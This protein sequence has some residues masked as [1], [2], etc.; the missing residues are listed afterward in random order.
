VRSNYLQIATLLVYA[1]IW[2]SIAIGNYDRVLAQ[3]SLAPPTPEICNLDL[4]AL[5]SGA[6]S[7]DRQMIT[8]DTVTADGMT[9]P[10]LWWTSEQFPAKLIANWLA[11]TRQKQ[12]YLV[13]NTQYW[14][15]L[16]Y[17]ERYRTID[18]FGRVAASYGYNLKICNTQ[19]I[20][21]AHYTCESISPAHSAEAGK[22]IGANSNL[23]G[24]TA[25]NNCQIWLNVSGQNGIGVRTN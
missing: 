8:A 25:P 16:D 4:A 19:K 3:S 22:S 17:I 1:P 14:N 21:L 7:R 20:S 10:S 11:N 15:V 6:L 23:A 12:I 5:K 2:L 13:V 24:T 9:V 18:K